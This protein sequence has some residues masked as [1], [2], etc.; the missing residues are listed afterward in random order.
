MES[1]REKFMIADSEQ[2]ICPTVKRRNR[3]SACCHTGN[4]L[5]CIGCSDNNVAFS[6]FLFGMLAVLIQLSSLC[7]NHWFYTIE[8][9]AADGTD[10]RGDP[11]E[12]LF[13][14]N[15]GYWWICREPYGDGF[16]NSSTLGFL[17]G[18]EYEMQLAVI[19]HIVSLCLT[20]SSVALSF[21]GFLRKDI[22]TLIASMTYILSGIIISMSVLQFICVLEDEMNTRVKPTPEG[23][24]SKYRSY[25]GWSF[26]LASCSFIFIQVCALIELLIY[27]RRYNTIEEK[28]VLNDGPWTVRNNEQVK[29]RVI[30][31][32]A[33][34]LNVL[35]RPPRQYTEMNHKYTKVVILAAILVTAVVYFE[36]Y[37]AVQMM[38]DITG[39]GMFSTSGRKTKFYLKKH[40]FLCEEILLG[41]S[42]TVA[43]A[44]SKKRQ[45]L[46]EFE[47]Y[48]I[49]NDCENVRSRH[50]YP[51]RPDSMQE[52]NFPIA[53]VIL[54][55][56]HLEQ[57]EMLLNAIYAPQNVYCFHVDI[58]APLLIHLAMKRLAGCFPN[59]VV[60][61][62]SYAISR[63]TSFTIDAFVQCIDDLYR[64][65]RRHQR[66][67]WKYLITLQNH[68]F[69]LKTN[70]EIVNILKMY[71][72][73]N[74]V[75]LMPAPGSRTQNFYYYERNSMGVPEIA[76][77]VN[78]TRGSRPFNVTFYKGSVVASLSRP[79][80]DH[81][82]RHPIFHGL[83][84]YLKFSFFGDELFWSTL[85][86]NQH[87]G[88]PGTYPGRCA[89]GGRNVWV[90]RLA[91]WQSGEY[92][93]RFNCCGKWR[94]TVCVQSTA[95]LRNLIGRPELF[96][97]KFIQSFD[98]IAID[99]IHELL[100]HRRYDGWKL[101]VPN[102]PYYEQASAVQ[103]KN[104]LNAGKKKEDF[105]CITCTK[106][107]H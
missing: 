69:P 59:V 93:E 33:K 84:S 37:K 13:I 50:F 107:A 21:F 79:F 57:V 16:D 74:D 8:P 56:E 32:S 6:N 34:D 35:L 58:K 89:S 86:H 95:D 100:Y 40:P 87:L 3:P 105:K 70:L 26:V 106:C 41:N 76:K 5:T 64:F 102:M 25:Y 17:E 67:P 81:L 2:E 52:S 82:R 24:P 14:Y 75:E 62:S 9:R 28:L 68:D 39:E 51:D 80:L 94:N 53:Y 90:S 29:K 20:T 92:M 85:S 71:G 22:R 7:S 31:V 30:E 27:L 44:V 103:Y 77:T 65:E 55:N 38:K 19:L 18:S 1:L 96:V 10:E 88:F 11:K 54:I 66:K 83:K 101:G 78:L 36:I 61:S 104:W 91:V 45:V 73:F 47:C 60:S 49:F 46:S 43:E 4:L 63:A 97:N 48:E 72:G 98:V 23:E 15:A 12:V 99:C 42:A